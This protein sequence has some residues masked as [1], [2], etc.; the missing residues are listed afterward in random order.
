MKKDWTYKKLGEVCDLYQPQTIST[1]EMVVGGEFN[2]YG[3]NGIIGKYNK[4]NHEKPEVLMTC[5]GATCGNINISTPKSWINGNAMVIHI[6]DESIIKRSFLVYALSF[7]DKTHIIT[8]A[9]QPQITRQTLAPLIFAFPPLSEQSRIVSRLD[10]AFGEIEGLKAKAEA[11]LSEARTL[12]QAALTQ[13]MK[14]KQ[15]W[16]EKKLK[17]LC[18]IINGFAFPSSVFGKGG[19]IKSI[20]ITNVG[21]GVFVEDQQNNVPKVYLDKA[22]EAIV[23]EKDIV[24]AL[25][26]TIINGGL[27]VAVVPSSYNYS[28]LNQRVAALRVLPDKLLMEYIYYFFQTQEAAQYVLKKV[29]TLMQPNLSIKDLKDMPIPYCSLSAQQSIVSR[30]DALSEKVREL[31]EAQKKVIAEC[32]ALK[33]ALLREVFE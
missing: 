6:K 16:E 22:A 2:V 30:L 14:P 1:K 11:Q 8:G 10:A 19:E 20:K 32:D 23:K 27:K 18:Q 24:V 28:L 12:F 3:A 15:G 33:Q 29:N 13:E 31:E 17:D 26:R 5:R 7:I 21:V 25:T 9:A 4:Y